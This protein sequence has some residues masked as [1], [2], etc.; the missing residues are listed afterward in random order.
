MSNASKARLASSA[1]S[2]SS[3]RLGRLARLER[4]AMAGLRGLGGDPTAP[5]GSERILV[6]TETGFARL[7]GR[8]VADAT[9]LW[10]V[11]RNCERAEAAMRRRARGRDD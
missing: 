1:S 9:W 6:Q 2:E 10:R 3:V 7:I 11:Q 5:P 4:S 8:N